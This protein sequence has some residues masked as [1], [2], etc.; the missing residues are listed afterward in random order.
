LPEEQQVIRALDVK[1]V[2]AL[3]NG[4]KDLRHKAAI[5]LAYYHG[6]RRKEICNLR[7]EDID[8]DKQIVAVLHKSY[9]RTKTK[10][11]R[12]V[13]LRHETGDLLKQLCVQRTNEFVFEKPVAFYY[14]VDKWFKKIVKSVGISYCTLHDL[15]KYADTPLMP[16]KVLYYGPLCR[17]MVCTVQFNKAYSA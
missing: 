3:L 7:W 11:S 6:L 15:R 2:V 13:A 14:S 12:S 9:A 8:F 16:S 17:K 1:E 4:A 5:S 10:T